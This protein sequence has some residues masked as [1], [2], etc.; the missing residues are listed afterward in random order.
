MN[1]LRIDQFSVATVGYQQTSLDYALDSIAHNGFGKV[2]LWGAEPHVC[3]ARY[4]VEN[5]RQRIRE[6]AGMLRARGL[7]MDVYSPEQMRIYPINI[8]SPDKYIYTWSKELMHLYLEDA[9]YLG[10][11]KM[12]VFPG[13]E[14]IDQPSDENFQR[15]ADVIVELGERAEKL[16]IDLISEPVDP[17]ESTFV[18]NLSGLVK[19]IDRTGK[20]IHP[21]MDLPAA[22][23]AGE[24]VGQWIDTVGMPELVHLADGNPDGYIMLGN[25]ENDIYGQLKA[26]AD[27]GYEGEIALTFNNP[28]YYGDPDKPVRAA[29]SWLI[30]SGLIG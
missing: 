7:T 18:T 30:A 23:S 13:W 16:G 27:A 21:C 26:L 20:V 29:W 8:A 19:L 14:Y 1:K 5:H 17:C 2:E 25:G 22:A 15:A 12:M 4:S 28:S 10:A 11:K 3:W 6:I 24:T 9:A